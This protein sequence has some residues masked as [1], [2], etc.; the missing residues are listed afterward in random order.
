MKKVLRVLGA[1][2]VAMVGV[3]AFFLPSILKGFGYHPD[4]EKKV[5]CLKGKKALIITTSHKT[6]GDTGKKTGVY[7]SEMTVPYY[8]FLDAGMEVEI[9]S[10]KGGEIP[11][12]PSSMRYPLASQSDRRY[13]KDITARMKTQQSLNVEK[14]DFL[15]YDIIFLAGGWGAAYDLGYSEILGE[16]LTQ[17]NAKGILIGSVCHGA[18]GFRKAKSADG[19]PLVEG[20]NVTA[21]SNKQIRELGIEATPLHP[22]TELRKQHAKYQCSRSFSDVFA[23]LVVTDGNMVTGQNQNSAGAAAQQ[24][25]K[26]LDDNNTNK[27]EV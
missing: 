5:Y 18:L 16:K 23:T 11:I 17:A 7:G 14:V 22:E 19:S 6:L 21:V 9:A 20:R 24:L 4:Y 12:E 15:A 10:I 3:V 2:F 27:Q 26:L 25:L 8:E 1:A 13:M